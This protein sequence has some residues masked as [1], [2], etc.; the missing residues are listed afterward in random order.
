MV[1]ILKTNSDGNSTVIDND[2]V[3]A[4]TF[5]G[6]AIAVMASMGD[7]DDDSELGD[8]DA[9]GEEEDLEDDEVA[10]D[11]EF[12]DDE[13]EAFGDAE[14]EDATEEEADDDEL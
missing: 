9:F 3:L 10:E 13:D 7:E 1:T 8:G 12:L 14:G 4:L 2:D 5:G 11:D 6:G